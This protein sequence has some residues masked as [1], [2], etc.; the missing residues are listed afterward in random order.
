MASTILSSWPF[1]LL[2]KQDDLTLSNKLL[3]SLPIPDQTKQFVFAFREPGSQS[4]VY[5]LAIVNL[6]AR[7]AADSVHLINAVKPKA[8]IAQISPAALPDIQQEEQCFE[9]GA[10]NAVPT[11]PFGVLKKCFTDKISKHEFEKIAG[12]EVLQEI[13]GIGFFGHFLAAKKAADEVDSVFLLLESPYDDSN[14]DS[15]SVQGEETGGFQLDANCLV[16]GGI[17]STLNPNFRKFC[18][19][20]LVQ[21]QAVKSLV[22]ALNASLNSTLS[23]SEPKSDENNKLSQNY[24][25]PPFA[26]TIY[27]LLSDLHNIFT[28]IPSIEKALISSQTL[29]S[30]IEQGKPTNSHTLSN[31]YTFRLAIEGLRVALNSAARN[32]MHKKDASSFAQPEFENLPSEE[33]SHVLFAQALKTQAKKFGSVVAIVDASCLCGIRRHWTTPVPPELESLSTTCF[34]KYS[35]EQ[36]QLD[37]DEENYG[38]NPEKK[39]LLTDK[40]MVAVGAGA[41]AVLGYSSL[42]KAF[43]ASTFFKLSSYKIPWVLKTAFAQFQR[44]TAVGL[45]KLLTSSKF[46]SA[47]K[48]RAVTHSMIASAEKTSLLAMRTSFYEIMQK[49]RIGGK[50]R[51]FLPWVTFGCSMGACS[52]LLMYGDGIECVAESAPAVAGIASLGRGLEGLRNVGKEVRLTSGARVQEALEGFMT[53]LK[54][55][56]R[57]G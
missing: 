46:L 16:P 35:S 27:P 34:T 36:D 1:S 50:A 8:V 11:S 19:S 30:S 43:H 39:H 29:L 9:Q 51:M 32:P 52:G 53:G 48:I 22:P 44:K 55:K 45:G 56:L 40:P 12:F 25:P 21:T 14:E 2:T 33:K 20:E 5:V 57:G 54:K 6:S 42:S 38:N 49:R 41:T 10:F 13:F 4:I 23:F 24:E 28:E 7:S 18:L 47:G 3:Q 37:S 17:A 26:R 31:V 15:D